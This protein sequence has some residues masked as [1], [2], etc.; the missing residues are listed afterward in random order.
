MG[1]EHSTWSHKEIVLSLYSQNFPEYQQTSQISGLRRTVFIE[2]PS[3]CCKVDQKLTNTRTNNLSSNWSTT[4]KEKK[5]TSNFDVRLPTL[6]LFFISAE[7]ALPLQS[8]STH[9]SFFGATKCWLPC[10]K[11]CSG[12]ISGFRSPSSGWTCGVRRLHLRMKPQQLPMS[13]QSPV[14]VQMS[15][16]LSLAGSDKDVSK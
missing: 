13:E 16:L 12:L 15:G 2:Q 7:P 9:I 11:A 6:L 3:S 5:K 10:W 14:E 1:N 8:G 4:F